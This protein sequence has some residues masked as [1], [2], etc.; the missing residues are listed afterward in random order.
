L[1]QDTAGFFSTQPMHPPENTLTPCATEPQ[2][3][4]HSVNENGAARSE[5]EQERLK[6]AQLEKLAAAAGIIAHDFNNILTGLMGNLSLAQL[7]AEPGS[8]LAQCL[9]KAERAGIR[10][11]DMGCALS[12]FSHDASPET[13]PASSAPA[14]EAPQPPRE[15][16][17]KDGPVRILIMDDESSIRELTGRML[18]SVG[19]EV[20]TANEGED[21]FRQYRAA[22]DA[23]NPFDAVL[24]DLRVPLGMGGYEAFQA[25]RGINPT[26]KAIISSGQCENPIMANYRQHGIAAVV[27]K[28]YKVHEL[29]NAVRQAVA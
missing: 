27:P 13:K 26:V 9:A 25:I 2:G 23:G 5:L 10:L 6:C 22:M 17:P 18:S 3:I 14:P 8:T 15:S 29:L 24:L 20:K 21:A 12:A 11:R 28:P 4:V 19:F 7:E 1:H 16:R